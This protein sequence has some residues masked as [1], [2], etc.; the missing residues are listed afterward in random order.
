VNIHITGCGIA[1]ITTALALS[2]S[3]NNIIIWEKE[4]LPGMYATSKN[5]A[6][7]RTYESDPTLS[8]IAKQS[9]YEIE[10]IEKTEGPLLNK[11]GIFIDPMEYDYHE[12]PY[13]KKFPDASAISS[14]KK[15]IELPGGKSIEGL[16]LASNGVLDTHALVSILMKKIIANGVTINFNSE[17]TSLETDQ[18]IISFTVNSNQIIN[19]NDN[20]IFINAAGSWAPSLLK[21]NQQWAP[22]VIPHKRHLFFIKGATPLPVSIPVIWSEKQ[23]FYIRPE[24]GGF[25]ASHCDQKACNPDD[26]N[27]DPKEVNNFL[28]ALLYHYPFFEDYRIAKY[29]ACIRTFAL[30]HHPVIGYDPF[31]NNLFWVS[32][33]GGRGM[34]I[35]TGIINNIKDIFFKN[36][37]T[38]FSP[39]RFI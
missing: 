12:T 2:E 20:D 10:K 14:E 7:F 37:K 32:G 34:T 15:R 30:D 24:T 13:L 38:P 23:D 25:L 5:A 6:I 22:P 21:K 9:Y 3:N 33:W 31:I 4:K 27:S 39:E 26:Y 18:K 17:I 36:L 35:A 11:T 19:L 1:G 29:W 8:F 28:N 16:Y